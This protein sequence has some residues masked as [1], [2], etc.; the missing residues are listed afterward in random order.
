MYR[1]RIYIYI[2]FFWGGWGWVAKISNIILGCLIFPIC[3]GVKV[4]AW[5]KPTYEEK[6]RDPHPLGV[7]GI[8]IISGLGCFGLSLWSANRRS[9]FPML[10][11]ASKSLVTCH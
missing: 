1:T 7:K 8:A 11:S 2:F 3:L 5:P 9:R 4:D 10:L 6:K